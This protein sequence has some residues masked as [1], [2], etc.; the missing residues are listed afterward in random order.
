[1]QMLCAGDRTHSLFDGFASAEC[2]HDGQAG[3]EQFLDA[4]K[5]NI[6]GGPGC[7]AEVAGPHQGRAETVCSWVGFTSDIGVVC[8]LTCLST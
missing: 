1:M 7:S 2:G 8:S 4:T 5:H 3:A 6:P